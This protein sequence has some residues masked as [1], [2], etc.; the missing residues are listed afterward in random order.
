[1]I[2]LTNTLYNKVSVIIPCF[3]CHS[4]IER[5]VK[6]VVNQTLPVFEIILVEDYSN[7]QLK[8]LYTLKKIQNTY[9]EKLVI[10]LIENKIN[11]GPGFSRN[12]A[13]N[14]SSGNLIAFLDAD[15]AW[16]CN[17]LE[18]QINHLKNNPEIVAVCNLDKYN[19]KYNCKEYHVDENKK[20]Y[21]I[22]YNKMLFKNQISTRS[23]LIKKSVPSR[24]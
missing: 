5:A 20:F 6:S 1:M 17:K 8:T 11:R 15:D 19:L 22:D 14:C 10:K 4:T 7:D 9:K 13:W 3:R 2:K 24:F 16:H 23:I 18:I 21:S 12:V